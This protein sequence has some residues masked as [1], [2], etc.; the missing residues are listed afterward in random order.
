MDSSVQRSVLTPAIKGN[1]LEL[2]RRRLRTTIDGLS[3]EA[4]RPVERTQPLR[5]SFAQERLWFLDRLG[6]VGPAYNIALAVRLRR[7]IKG[8][9]FLILM[10]LASIAFAF[11][12]LWNPVAGAAAVI[13][14]IAWYAVILGVLGIIFG[15]RLRSLPTLPVR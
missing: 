12:L 5:L 9:W 3:I 11:L 4:I 14:I 6:L 10:G 15:F 7:E 13:W 1:K 8:E 2:L